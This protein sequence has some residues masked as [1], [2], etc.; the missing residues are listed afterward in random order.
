M[1]NQALNT[2]VVAALALFAISVGTV[3]AG[4]QQRGPQR[5]G[6]R[7]DRG[8]FLRVQAGSPFPLDT[9]RSAAIGHR[10]VVA[11]SQPLAAL[12]GLDILKQGGNAIDAAI[13]TA[14]VL[15]VVEPHSTALGGDMFAMVYLAEE[16]KLVGLNGSGRAAYGMTLAAL[17]E[18]LNEQDQQRISG[19][20]SVTVPGAV[21]GWFTLHDEYGSMS[22]AE[23]LAP[24]IYYAENGFHV[25]ER[26]G[27]AWAGSARRLAGEPSSA[28]TWLVDGR[29]P[30][31]GEL[32][33][34]KDL[35][36]TFRALATEGRDAFYKGAI[37]EKIVA[38]SDEK[39]GFLTMKD[40]EDHTS[41]WVEPISTDYKNYTLHE[42]PPNGQGI[43]ALEMLNTLENVDMKSFGH[44]S[45]EYLHYLIEAK[46]L[47]Y[48]DLSQWVGDPE[49]NALPIDE[50]ISKPYGKKQSAR[51]DPKQAQE[52]VESGLPA[53]GDT[54]YLSVMDK[55]HNAVSFI[56]SIFA[57]FGSG[58][59]VPGTGITLQN[60]GALFSL[61]EGHVNVVAPHKRPFHTIIPAMA[62]KDGEF[63]MTFG[64]MG[65]SVQPQQHVQVFLNVVEFGMNM[66]QAL[67]A[68]RINHGSGLSVTVEPGIDEA[69][70]AKLEAWGHELRRRDTIGGVGGGQGIIFDAKTGAMIGGSSHHKDGMA[71]AY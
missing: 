43:A 44:N 31:V 51:I 27:Q 46:K 55:D 41:T 71:V 35:G 65:G 67:E 1:R 58:L 69:I 12:A 40:F 3:S 2:K 4:S 62:F 6:Q 22:M 66:Q 48:A 68:P 15:T 38:Y 39:N 59:T 63:F 21:D 26:I 24:A 14:A 50:L 70:L 8:G 57:S 54:I 18:R 64:V 60:R 13:A 29:A 36:A 20:Y 11:T 5:G 34:N 23:V 25:T 37:A 10:G 45:A 52:R 16:D 42:L 30:A 28:E 53:E 9:K 7:G 47:A 17:E 32:F 33:V 61:E 49:A 56:Y 19:I